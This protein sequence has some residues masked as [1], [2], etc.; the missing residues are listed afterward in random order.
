MAKRK[1]AP[2]LVV[3]NQAKAAVKQKRLLQTNW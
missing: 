3:Q 2:S 1:N